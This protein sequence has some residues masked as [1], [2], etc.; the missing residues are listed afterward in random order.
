MTILVTGGRGHVARSIVRHLL[1]AGESV[2]VGSRS[3][4]SVDVPQGAEV[5]EVDLA[6]P[7]TLPAALRGISKVFVYADPAGMGP[8]VDAA[9][10]AGLKHVVLL[11][12]GVVA[13]PEHADFNHM[14]RMH[15]AAEQ[16]LIGSG[17]PWTFLRPGAFNTNTLH[18]APAIRAER[19]VRAAHPGTHVDTIHED[20]VAAVAVRAFTEPGHEGASYVLTGPESITQEEQ[21]KLIGEA[22]GHH[23][24]FVE[25]TPEQYKQELGDLAPE[26]AVDQL[27]SFLAEYDGVPVPIVN[28]VAAV[29]GRRARSFAQWAIDHAD[30]FR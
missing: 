12:A 7:E 17:I 6:R 4:A 5:V 3:P 30:D 14:A 23:V 25:L 8:F 18:W 9:V 29:T 11:S 20:D 26:E 10:S 22:I 21:V 15:R 27:L 24:Q 19:A 28:T 16:E 13:L 2:R 1:A